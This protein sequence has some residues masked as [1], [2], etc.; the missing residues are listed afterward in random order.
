MMWG[1][2]DEVT[3]RFTAAG[4][5]KENIGFTRDSF[6]FNYPG[7]PSGFVGVFR[8][9]SAPPMT[10]SPAGAARG[11]ADELQDELEALFTR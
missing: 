5:P 3:A 11:R 1:I 6:T 10:A 2:E 9:L 7:S 4:I 8:A